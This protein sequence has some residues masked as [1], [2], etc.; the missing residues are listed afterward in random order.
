M[1]QTRPVTIT[2]RNPAD[3]REVGAVPIDS[4]DTVA[5]KAR[6]LRLFQPAWEELG[7]QGRRGW[8]LKFQDWILDHEQ[9]IVDIIQSETGKSRADASFEPAGLASMVEYWAG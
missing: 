5:G 1:T 8:L 3:G 4:A 2:V 9:Q 7:P 6:E